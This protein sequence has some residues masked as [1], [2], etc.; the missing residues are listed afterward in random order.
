M[1]LKMRIGVLLCAGVMVLRAGGQTPQAVFDVKDFGAK[2]DG[3]TLDTEAINKAIDACAAAGGGTVSIVQ[4]KYLSGTIVLK[5]HV[6]LALDA[7]ATL[8]A[9]ENR[10]DYPP[11]EDV[12]E[13]GR[14]SMSP[15]I[16]ADRAEDITITGRGLIDGQGEPWWRP[17]LETKGRGRGGAATQATTPPATQPARLGN[18]GNGGAPGE[19]PQLVRLVHCKD[20]V[21]EHVSLKDSPS[22][23]IHPMMCENVRVDGVTITAVVPSPNTDGI[24]PE[25]CRNVQIVNCRIDNGDDCIT[26]KSGLNE[27]GRKMGKPDEDITIS[28]C[29]MY[30]GHGGVTIG[31][32]MSGGVRNVV[33]TNCVFQ[34]TDV[35]IRV[36]SQRGRGGV[37][38]GLSVSNVV[39]QDVPHPFTITTFY[40][41]NDKPED[42]F[43]VDEGTPRFRDF[44]FSNISARGAMEAGSVTGLKEMA[45]ENLTFTNVHVQAKKGFTC[46]SA[47]GLKFQDCVIDTDAGA[48]MTL[49]GCENIDTTRLGT[50][51]PHEGTSLVEEVGKK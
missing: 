27:A 30:H 13:A 51:T 6:T 46:T 49:R 10:S 20:V 21:I 24:N 3:T 26:L 4:G 15:L 34:G 50:Q 32:E 37:V 33:V 11:V 12:W 1:N 48:A 9:S 25:S 45:I 23:N 40:M 16:Y 31:S 7:S 18:R 17:I 14:K 41:G 5:S 2:G 8:L 19:R 22:W 39:M 36:K 44:L 38:E 29:V 42:V 28:N 47:K 43:P 35:G